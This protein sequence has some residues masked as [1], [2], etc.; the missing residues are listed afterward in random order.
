MIT[1]ALDH[2]LGSGQVFASFLFIAL[3]KPKPR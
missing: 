3:G 2:F 1:H